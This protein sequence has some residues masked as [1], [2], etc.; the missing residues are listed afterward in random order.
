MPAETRRTTL[1]RRQQATL[2]RLTQSQVLFFVNRSSLIAE[3]NDVVEEICENDRETIDAA[4]S[5]PLPLQIDAA[6]SNDEHDQYDNLR[7]SPP[8]LHHEDT[9]GLSDFGLGS[10]S[11]MSEQHA[12]EHSIIDHIVENPPVRQPNDDCVNL[13]VENQPARK[14]DSFRKQIG[15]I[16]NDGK[17]QGFILALIVTNAIMMGVATFPFVKDNPDVSAKFELIDEIFLIFELIDEIFL[18]VFSIEAAIQLTYH[19]LALLKDPWLVFDLTVV[20]L[21]WALEGVKGF[22]AFRIFRALRLIARVDVMRNLITALVSVLP[23][24]T[25]ILLLLFLVFYIFSVLFTVLYKDVS[26]EYPRKQQYFV[27]LPETFFTLFQMMTLDGLKNIYIQAYNEYWWSSI[28]IIAFIIITA[29]AFAN[30][31]VAVICDAVHVLGDDDVAGLLGYAED[32]VRKE[33]MI[34]GRYRRSFDLLEGL[35][36]LTINRLKEMEAQLD[37]IVLMKDDLMMAMNVLV[38]KNETLHAGLFPVCEEFTE[39]NYEKQLPFSASTSIT[40]NP[41]EKSERGDNHL[42]GVSVSRWNGN[43][44][45]TPDQTQDYQSEQ[46]KQVFPDIDEQFV[47]NTSLVEVETPTISRINDFRVQ[48]GYI[49]N[50]DKVQGFILALIVIN[51]IMMGVATFHFIK[52]NPDVSAKFELI[53]LV[54]L[55]VFT[56]EATMQ[57][58][59]HGWALFKDAWLVFDLTV[60]ALSWALEGVK[61]FRAFRIFRALRLVARIDAM[62]NLIIAVIS[63]IPNL[64][65]IGMLLF[66]V[67]YI[68]AVMF[69]LLFKDVSKQYPRQ[70]QYFVALPETFFTLFQM[71]TLDGW[72]NIFAQAYDEYWWSWIPF[73]AFV[74]VTAFVFVNLIVAVICDA[75]H[76]MSDR[77]LAGLT[78]YDEDEITKIRIRGP[79]ELSPRASNLALGQKLREIERSIDEI[80]SIQNQMV[81]IIDKIAQ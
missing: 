28:F 6:L 60:V 9:R 18:I 19:G 41:D 2:G 79:L 46:I 63:V 4:G 43:L 50:D 31:I 38:S 64:T 67:F 27:A 61:G 68:F 54:F 26:D 8:P 48:M 21:S 13:D 56:I 70:Q 30:L 53:D 52:D 3:V 37:Q 7:I 5:D 62:K 39:Q 14:L 1:S 81:T 80:V 11:K 74:V 58:T 72:K 78:G 29:F 40:T 55:I 34:F 65:G 76:V 36:S 49:V 51:A 59:Y 32:E 22:R 16:V 12:D 42:N 24:L 71:M 33:R 25:G 66:L 23:N 47:E 44:D 73:V 17:V 57:L 45:S 35:D 77:G 15:C 69:T 10:L 75:V 20:A